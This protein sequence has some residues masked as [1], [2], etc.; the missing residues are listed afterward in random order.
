[1]YAFLTQYYSE[2]WVTSLTVA[3]CSQRLQ[4]C[5]VKEKNY[6]L[7]FCSLSLSL[8]L[9]HTHVS[10]H[11]KVRVPSASLFHQ[12]QYFSCMEPIKY[13]IKKTTVN[14]LGFLFS[15]S[16]SDVFSRFIYTVWVILMSFLFH[17][18]LFLHFLHLSLWNKQ[19]N[20]CRII[21]IILAEI[22]YS[23]ESQLYGDL[24]IFRLH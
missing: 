19:T 6:T 16:I 24:M 18:I 14:L 2:T 10:K 9:T 17:C 22:I 12:F 13:E 5:F 4:F 21:N 11:P 23:L 15:R 3:D 8:S 20:N 7:F 1:M